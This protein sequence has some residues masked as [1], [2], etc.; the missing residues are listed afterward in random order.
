VDFKKYIS[1]Q[2]L[3]KDIILTHLTEGETIDLD[4]DFQLLVNIKRL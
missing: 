2:V 4:D 1:N 3:A